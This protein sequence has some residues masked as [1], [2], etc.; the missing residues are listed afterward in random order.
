MGSVMR[1]DDDV[2]TAA[3]S[4]PKTRTV[5]P[6]VLTAFRLHNAT[7]RSKNVPP[8]FYDKY[9]EA[10]AHQW[11]KYLAKNVGENLYWASGGGFAKELW[12]GEGMWYSGQRVGGP[13]EGVI[14]HNT[15]CRWSRT[16]RVGMA[17]VGDGREVGGYEPQRNFVGQKSY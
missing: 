11:A 10:S 3:T 1:Y 14:G 8:L 12:L 4:S 7:R 13:V 9:L 5:T 6:D 2:A 17:V 15:Q 16:A